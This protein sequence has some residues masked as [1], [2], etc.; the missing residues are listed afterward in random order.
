MCAKFSSD[1]IFYT[2]LKDN[3][4]I[5]CDE[6]LKKAFGQAKVPRGEVLKFLDVNLTR[7]KPGCHA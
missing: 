2:F 3:D 1:N 4:E 7:L 6:H 5:V